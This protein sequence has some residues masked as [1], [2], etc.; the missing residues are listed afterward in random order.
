M[1]FF[2][3]C[4][5]QVS[6]NETISPKCSDSGTAAS[7]RVSVAQIYQGSEICT[8]RLIQMTQPGVFTQTLSQTSSGL[9]WLPDEKKPCDASL[10]RLKFKNA[11]IRSKNIT[12]PNTVLINHPR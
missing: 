10:V 4:A 6:I 9:A 1:E 12:W 8:H 5:V 7:V 2:K 11:E 3:K